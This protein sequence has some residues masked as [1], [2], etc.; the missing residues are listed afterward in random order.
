MGLTTE[1]LGKFLGTVSLDSDDKPYAKLV[2]IKKD[3]STLG[4]YRRAKKTKAKKATITGGKDFSE[5]AK[6]A[7]EEKKKKK[8]ETA[9]ELKAAFKEQQKREQEKRARMD[10]ESE[11]LF[12]EVGDDEV[13]EE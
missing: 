13:V 5:D 3:I 9:E 6:K 8:P 10:A 4:I 7:A 1:A 12:E 2:D 11:D